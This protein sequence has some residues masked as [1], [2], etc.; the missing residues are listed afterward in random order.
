MIPGKYNINIWRGSTWSVA[1]QQDSLDFSDYDE[2]RMQI[3]PPFIKGIPVKAALLELT[4]DN[5]RITLEDNNQTLRLTISAETTE[6]FSF[7][8]GVYD[9]E[10]VKHVN[11]VDILEEVVDK[12]LYGKVTVQGE[13]TV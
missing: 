1:I 3:R 4:L 8:E 5:G 11:G 7:N 2:I 12:L 6:E 10:M 13:Q 9:L